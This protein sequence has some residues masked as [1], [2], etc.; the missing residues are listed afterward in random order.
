MAAGWLVGCCCSCAFAIVVKLVIKGITVI[1]AA[2]SI[3]AIDV[4]TNNREEILIMSRARDI[5]Q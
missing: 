2:V 3:I 1:A 5:S 4:E